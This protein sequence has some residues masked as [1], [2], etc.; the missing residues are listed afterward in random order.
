[1]KIYWKSIP[2]LQ[3]ALPFILGVL[4]YDSYSFFCNLLFVSSFVIL[5]FLVFYVTKLTYKFRWVF[6]L[7]LHFFVFQLAIILSHFSFSENRTD[8]F[9]NYVN[10]NSIFLIE[11]IEAPQ[12][13]DNSLQLLAQVSAVD[14]IKTR[15]KILIYCKKE[16]SDSLKKGGILLVNKKPLRFDSP[17]NPN[18]F[19]FG[20][21]LKQKNIDHYLFLEQGNYEIVGHTK[22]NFF[23][24]KIYDL[25][26]RLLLSLKNTKLSDDEYGFAS[27]IL[28]GDRSELSY[29][30]K[31]AFS[32]TGSMHFLAVSGLHVGIIYLFIAFLFP[33]RQNRILAFLSL[34]LIL[35]FLWT[36]ALLCGMSVSVVRA[37]LMLSFVS[38]AKYLNKNSTVINTILLSAFIL[39]L[40]NPY[41]LFDVGF[42]LSYVAVIGIVL[43]YPKLYALISPGY[44]I[45]DWVWKVFCLSLSAQIAT[46]GLSI[47]YFHQF[48]NYLFYRIFYYFL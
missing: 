30:M 28:L 40:I 16:N 6:G 20:I 45:T 8:Y 2:L 18:Q 31:S 15:G 48:P 33:F 35:L 1:M 23:L 43:I 7:L 47:Y 34:S 27:A 19:D 17:K 21:F 25:R 42:Q 13:K 9:L 22:S 12:N 4:F 29:Q 14:Q 5:L 37:V 46:A 10:E 26:I 44:T 36:Y 39:L 11:I 41:S 24:N 3:F 32:A 38:I